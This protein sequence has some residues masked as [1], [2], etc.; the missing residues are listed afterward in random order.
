MPPKTPLPSSRPTVRSI[1]ERAGVSSA[2]VS[3]ALRGHPRISPATRKRVLR[4]AQ[5]IGYRPDPNVA[6]LMLHLR[7]R[8]PPGFQ[9]MLAALTTVPEENEQPYLHQVL[10]SARERADSLGYGLMVVRLDDAS[11]PR[12]DIDRMLRARGVEGV[13][14]LPMKTPRSFV[15][16]LDWS[17]FS[18]VTATN[19][20]LAPE[21]HR[22]VPHQFN[23]TLT[24]CEELTRRGYRRIGLVVNSRHDLTVGHG[25]SAAVVWQ[26]VLGG[27]ERVMPLV[28]DADEPAELKHWFEREHPD[29][30]IT[31]GATDAQTI[32]RELG[33]RVPGPVGFATTN[34]S[35]RSAFAGIEEHP[36]EV[37]AA[38]VRLLTSLIQHGEKGIPDVPTVTMVKGEWLDGRSVKVQPQ[39]R[40]GRSHKG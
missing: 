32:A 14:L 9:S 29:A 10:S 7:T 38:A 37:G 5:E 11:G 26:N 8:R 23:N 2:T 39:N 34:R 30:I 4:V 40:R 19:G 24:V 20:V 35:S 1:A 22:V 17:K 33:L 12:R 25:V 18:V 16:L 13:L 36:E 3:L 6:K 28:F 21:F 31:A 27:A 15:D